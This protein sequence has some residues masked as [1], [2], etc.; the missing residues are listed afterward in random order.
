MGRSFFLLLGL[1][2]SIELPPSLPCPPPRR[3]R[4]GNSLVLVRLYPLASRAEYKLVLLGETA[5]GKSSIA[6]SFVFNQFLDNQESTKGVSLASSKGDHRRRTH[7]I[8]IC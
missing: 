4:I 2:R 8:N 5:V 6:L 1:F 3:L 7:H